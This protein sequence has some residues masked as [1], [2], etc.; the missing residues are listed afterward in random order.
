M[1]RSVQL[2]AVVAIFA[3][4]SACGKFNSTSSSTPT[5]SQAVSTTDSV[6]LS[7]APPATR[8]DGSE[9]PT[10]ELAGYR[11][12]MGTSSTNL[13]PLVDLSDDSIT[14]YRVS[15]L[16]NGSYY[17]AVTAYDSNGLESGYSQTILIHLG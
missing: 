4:L 6:N 17:F 13:A 7:W 16:P 11:V 8:A 3:L 1:H 12:Y 15:N 5:S 2:L 9:L 10:G 14:E